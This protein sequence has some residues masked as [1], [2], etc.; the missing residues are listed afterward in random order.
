MPGLDFLQFLYIDIIEKS[1]RIM[2][3]ARWKIILFL[4]LTSIRKMTDESGSV[5]WSATYYPFGEMT[6]GSNNTHGF[7]GKEF[8]SE[9]GLNY[10]C[11]RYYD[12]EIGR[13]VTLDPFGGYIELPQ[14]QN[15]YAYCMGNPLKYI[16]SLGLV[17]QVIVHPDYGLCVYPSVVTTAPRYIPNEP[18]DWGYS[19][20]NTDILQQDFGEYY[21]GCGGNYGGKRGGRKRYGSGKSG[22][23]EKLP[24][25]PSL[26]F[27]LSETL[28]FHY[29]GPNAF[30]FSFEANTTL[31]YGGTIG[32]AVHFQQDTGPAAYSYL[33][34]NRGGSFGWTLGFYV[35]W[36][37]GLWGGS[38]NTMGGNISYFSASYF[39]SGIWQGMSI[40]I[41]FGV[42]VGFYSGWAYYV[43]H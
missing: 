37:Q 3:E 30:G 9:M 17:Y 5:V 28:F 10:F 41:G 34:A 39:E 13:F 40:G 2:S 33:G 42:P 25:I 24:K 12:P 16:D 20:E 27:G 36:G 18:Y 35:A 8:D 14:T 26:P 31:N 29:Y 4:L 32:E 11:Q 15:R 1:G 22:G 38:F 21:D 43:K 19:F 23:G 7:T 6:A